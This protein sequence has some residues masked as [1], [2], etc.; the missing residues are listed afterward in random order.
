MYFLYINIIINS[1]NKQNEVIYF[2]NILGN[3]K[4][5]L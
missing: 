4:Y 3:K 2:L 5:S 1:N